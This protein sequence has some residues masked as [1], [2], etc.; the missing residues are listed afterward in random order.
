MNSYVRFSYSYGY[1]LTLPIEDDET[2]KEIEK[3]AYKIL[4]KRR[5]MITKREL[6]ARLCEVEADVDYLLQMNEKLEKR[7]KKLEPK[8]EKVKK[9][10]KSSK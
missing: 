1:G 9:D 4:K 8:K 2:I 7:V 5:N 10:A 3:K 6:M